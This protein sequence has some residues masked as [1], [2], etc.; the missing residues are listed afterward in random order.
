MKI[1]IHR[2]IK[3]IGGCIT[4]IATQNTRILIDLGQNL[5]NNKGVVH[6]ELAT[7]E[8]VEKI[9]NGVNAILYTHNHG[10]H[11]GL[12]NLVPNEIPQYIG[13]VAQE[14]CICK[15]TRL[16]LVEE[17]KEKETAN[18]ET[19]KA[20]TPMFAGESFVVGD[21]KITPYFVSHSA[22]ESFMFLIEADGERVLHTGDF[23]DHGYLGKALEP[24][25]NHYVK[26]VDYLITEGTLLARGDEKVRSENELQQEFK[27]VMKKYKNVFVVSSSTDMERLATIQAAHKSSKT[28][29]PLICDVFQKQIFEIFSKHAAEK[30][31]TGL[32]RF[33]VNKIYDFRTSNE[34]LIKWMNGEGF[35]MLIRSTEKYH[36][37]LDEI[38]PTLKQEETAVVF[39]MWPEYINEKGEH[40]NDTYLNLVN[41]FEN[42]IRIHTSGHATKEC[43]QNVCKITNPKVV[44]PIH[45][46]GVGTFSI[47][48]SRRDDARIISTI[49]EESCTIDGVEIVVK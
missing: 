33:D 17:L 44:I 28:K 43:L 45:K 16:T 13:N 41:R 26:Q 11:V 47:P 37:W 25:L 29:A 3:Q 39:S 15:H 36:N 10:D 48:N 9:T 2:G 42:L 1:T 23:R 14:I 49:V 12:F 5:P 4:E 38:L 20:M 30:E 34:K 32:F 18:V 19:F 7:K 6:D 35:T 22:Y 8:A 31:K 46:D 21:I 40:T 24:M 27:E